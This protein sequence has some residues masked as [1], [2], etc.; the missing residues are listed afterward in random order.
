MN[1]PAMPGR[2]MTWLLWLDDYEPFELVVDGQ[3]TTGIEAILHW[4]HGRDYQLGTAIGDEWR[5]EDGRWSMRG[6]AVDR[7]TDPT[8]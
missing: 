6:K 2:V 4:L 5:A 1:A 8:T 7:A 3:A